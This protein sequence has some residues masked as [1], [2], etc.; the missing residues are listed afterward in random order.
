MLQPDSSVHAG[1]DKYANVFYIVENAEHEY[2]IECRFKMQWTF[3][4][5]FYFNG[6]VRVNLLN[7]FLLQGAF[8]N[9]IVE[10]YCINKKKT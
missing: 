8:F 3:Y 5:Q 2:I 7:M 1:M 6:S 10:F 4:S 9:N